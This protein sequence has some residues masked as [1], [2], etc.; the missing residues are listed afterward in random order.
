MAQFPNVRL[1]IYPSMFD[2]MMSV[3]EYNA[4]GEHT[5]RG[6]KDLM[7]KRMRFSRCYPG[8]NGEPYVSILMYDSEAAEMIWQLLVAC[9]GHFEVTKEYSRELAQTGQDGGSNA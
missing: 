2:L 5:Q 3:L 9:V 7:E 6:A 4:D 1:K 8:E